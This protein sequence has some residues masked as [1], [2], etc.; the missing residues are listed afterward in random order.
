MFRMPMKIIYQCLSCG[1]AFD[2]EEAAK[3]CHKAPVQAIE[4]GFQKWYKKK[5]LLGN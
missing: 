1:R 3:N 2:T 4:K 5:G